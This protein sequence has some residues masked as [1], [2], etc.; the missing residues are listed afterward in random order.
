MSEDTVYAATIPDQ[1]RGT[2]FASTPT[3]LRVTRI[4]T[5]DQPEKDRASDC[6]AFSLE[7][8]WFDVWRRN[9][10]GS[11][12]VDYNEGCVRSDRVRQPFRVTLDDGSEFDSV[13]DDGEGRTQ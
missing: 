8:G 11:L 12:A 5:I 13:V 9:E 7:D 6:P 10:D 1:L 4:T 2:V 3:A